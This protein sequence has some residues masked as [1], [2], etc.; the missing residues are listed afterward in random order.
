MLHTAE[1]C[2][3]FS[4]QISARLLGEGDSCGKQE[5]CIESFIAKL[6]GKR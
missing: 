3:C 5:K 2:D 6:E 4:C 1:R